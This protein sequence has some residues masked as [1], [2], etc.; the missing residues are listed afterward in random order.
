MSRKKA[1]KERP[2]RAGM[3]VSSALGAILQD[4]FNDL[5]RWESKAR[6]WDDIEGVHQMRVNARRMRSA[7]WSFRS[8]VPKDVSLHWR[9]ELRWIASQLGDARDLDVFIAEGLT[10][11]RDQAALAGRDE[12]M[13]LAEQRRAA[14]SRGLRGGRCDA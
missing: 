6:S 11:A 12:L 2:L 10:P 13:T 14:A 3:T 1:R 4:S 7:L 5:T 8:S 9:E